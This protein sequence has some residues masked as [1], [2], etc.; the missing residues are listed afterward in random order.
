MIRLVDLSKGA[1][2]MHVASYILPLSRHTNYEV[3]DGQVCFH[4]WSFA[5]PV[6]PQQSIT[7]SMGPL[8]GTDEATWD[9]KSLLTTVLSYQVDC[10]SFCALLKTQ[11]CCLSPCGWYRPPLASH[12]PPMPIFPR[13]IGVQLFY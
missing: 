6:K 8:M 13:N 5:D 12:P 10:G 4:R 2:H 3:I 11:H 1:V 7:E 9:V